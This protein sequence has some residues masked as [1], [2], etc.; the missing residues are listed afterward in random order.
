MRSAREHDRRPPH[1][2]LLS[3]PGRGH[4]S[5]G[6]PRPERHQHGVQPGGP[7]ACSGSDR[8]P[9]VIWTPLANSWWNSSAVDARAA[10]PAV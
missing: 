6:H 5:A 8:S 4:R 10:W 9:A 3:R 2:D 1:R 7:A